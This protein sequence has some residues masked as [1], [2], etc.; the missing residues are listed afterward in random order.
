MGLQKLGR[1]VDRGVGRSRV[2][3]AEGVDDPHDSVQ[4]PLKDFGLIPNHRDEHNPWHASGFLELAS[5]L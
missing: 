4:T 5:S 3:N 1:E 2:V